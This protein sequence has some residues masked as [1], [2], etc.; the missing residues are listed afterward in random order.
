MSSMVKRIYT[1]ILPA[2]LAVL[3]L[4]SGC[5]GSTTPAAVLPTNTLAP[6]V[7]LTPRFTATPQVTRTPPPTSTFT[8]S[9]T[10][11]PP[12]P[13]NTFT[14][15][16]PPP[17][18]GII[19]SLNTV[20]VR[21]GPAAS[22]PAFVALTPG[23]GVEVIG[24]NAEGTWLNV[25]LDDGQEGWV[26]R[27][28]VRIEATAAPFPT[29][30][31]ESGTENA[32]E[33][34]SLPTAVI[35]GSIVTPTLSAATATPPGTAAATA[36]ATI[37]LPVI[38]L[39]AIHS[40]ATALAAGL[41][42]STPGTP[43]AVPPTATTSTGGSAVPPTAQPT[44]TAAPG[45]ATVQQGVDVLAYCNNPAYG[46]RPPQNLAAGSTI[47]VYWGWFAKTEQQVRDHVDAAIYE[48]R[49]NGELL[50]NWRQ[51]SRPTRLESDNNYHIYWY[52]PS[53]PFEAGQVTITYRVTWREAISDGYASFG[54]ET[55]IP[56]QE[57]SCTFVVK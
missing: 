30:T 35:G 28:L 27:E 33:G 20:N 46:V 7:T 42:T 16:I 9:V 5:S 52:V 32:T 4:L 13:S 36:G 19:T 40:T 29:L 53:G 48:V 24:Q 57:G 45:T 1:F 55:N 22:F 26:F 51:Y 37:N 54:P 25:K 38:D 39:T 6:L 15:T 3:I 11:I 8:P 12:T 17:I 44:L 10:P 56:S 34:T 31:P 21:S 47:D 43:R 49:V 2:A 23:T 14:P 41:P 18:I 50:Q